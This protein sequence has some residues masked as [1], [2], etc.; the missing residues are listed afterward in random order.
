MYTRNGGFIEDV[1]KFDPHFFGISAREAASMDP[2]Q[3]LLLEAAW[4]AL[5]YGGQ[6]PKQLNGS[7]TGVFYGIVY[8]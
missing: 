5:E 2:Q 6:S 1:D 4:E 7:Q 3:R 8:G